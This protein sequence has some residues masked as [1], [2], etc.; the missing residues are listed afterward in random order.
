MASKIKLF[1]SG[2][3]LG[4]A[5]ALLLA[6]KSGEETRE[7]IAEKGRVGKRN[8]KA[9]AREMRRGAQQLAKEGRERVEQAVDAGKT[10]YNQ[11]LRDN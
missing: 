9:K 10:A 11:T 2:I 1:V 6:P 3:G 8:V 5:A 4:A 7:W